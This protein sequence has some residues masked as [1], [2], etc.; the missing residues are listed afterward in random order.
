MLCLSILLS[1]LTFIWFYL[2]LV[3]VCSEKV[4]IFA[5][6]IERGMNAENK[7]GIEKLF[8]ANYS[9]LYVYAFQMI[10]DTETS[11]DI[12]GDAFEYIWKNGHKLDIST[13]K[14]YLYTY[15]RTRCIDY[16]RHLQVHEQYAQFCLSMTSEETDSDFLEEEENQQ[17]LRKVIRILTPRTR[18]I[19]EEC[20]IR[21]KK[22]QEVADELEISVSAV[23]KHIMKALQAMRDEFAKKE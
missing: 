6:L 23:R 2:L 10:N 4:L 14:S 19:L 9:S 13:A 20:Y 1:F 17:R 16:I 3:K 8:K 11:R 22:Y 7:A 21:K 12:V 5:I 18:H 15:V